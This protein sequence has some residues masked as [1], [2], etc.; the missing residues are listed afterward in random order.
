MAETV[1]SMIGALPRYRPVLFIYL[2]ARLLRKRGKAWE[3]S[4]KIPLQLV[5]RRPGVESSYR[6]SKSS[7][8]HPALSLG[9]GCLN[10][11]MRLDGVET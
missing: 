5:P 1:I 10:Y 11:R 6:F 2:R 7:F 9:R 3:K 4:G 8:P